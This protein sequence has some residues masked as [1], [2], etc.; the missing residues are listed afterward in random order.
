MSPD[1][2]D[3]A[4]KTRSSDLPIAVVD[5]VGDAHPDLIRPGPER[6]ETDAGY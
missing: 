1:K 4:E 3:R 6:L 5:Q 2:P